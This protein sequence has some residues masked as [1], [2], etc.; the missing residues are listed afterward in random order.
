MSPSCSLSSENI[1]AL[2]LLNRLTAGNASLP[3]ALKAGESPVDLLA[4]IR[5]ENFLNLAE[6]LKVL[7]RKFDADEEREKCN[8]LGVS[9][10]FLN[11]PG[12]PDLLK[13]IHDPPL[14]LYVK[15]ALLPADAAASVA[16]VGA[17]HATDYGLYHAR[18]FARETSGYGFTIVSGLARGV[19]QA[20]HEGAL[21]RSSGRTLAVLGCGVDQ[22]YPPENR[23]L[24]ERIS[25]RGAVLSEYAL[26]AK[27]LAHHFPR[28]NRIISGLSLGV[29][30]IE[31]HIRS[32]SL[33]TAREALDQGRE[34]FAMPGRID[35]L[36]SQGTHELL[37]KG[38]CLADSS[39]VLVESLGQAA[40]RRLELLPAEKEGPG[41][42]D[43]HKEDASDVK[44]REGKRPDD[45]LE[46]KVPELESCLTLLGH[47]EHTCEELQLLTGKAA[48]DFF[49]WLLKMEMTG[50]LRRNPDGRYTV[51]VR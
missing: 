17:R 38:A 35:Q 42:L 23:R 10:I 37:R 43:S 6:E 47:S 41:E 21:E 15:G 20:A 3:A 13:E 31:A 34:V 2:L 8:R 36:T 51:N 32:G 14:V 9:C 12:Y 48:G 27:P 39:W 16:I 5:E 28:R 45:A 18:K 7:Q 30:V 50:F 44:Q 29:L 22:V 26:G 11:G 46:R 49:Q 24:Y 33:I 4:R 1:S 40:G 19:D 25:E